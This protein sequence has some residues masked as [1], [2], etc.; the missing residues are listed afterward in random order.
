MSVSCPVPTSAIDVGELAHD[1]RF[2]ADE[3]VEGPLGR[4]RDPAWGR[5][6]GPVDRVGALPAVDLAGQC[7]VVGE[8]ES[9]P[10]SASGEVLDVLEVDAR[11]RGL[12]GQ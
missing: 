5:V 1:R 11:Q 4:E 12:V 9:V 6:G 2:P 7:G 8:L 10:G 3:A